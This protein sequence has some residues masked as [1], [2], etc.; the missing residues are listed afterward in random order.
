M[1]PEQ[2]GTPAE[3][4]DAERVIRALEVLVAECEARQLTG[5]AKR[6]RLCTTKCQADYVAL[7]R[8][9]FAARNRK[10][11]KPPPTAH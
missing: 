3:L 7:Q 2:N 4:S 6:I 5:F 9:E 10:G 11:R 1:S 8:R